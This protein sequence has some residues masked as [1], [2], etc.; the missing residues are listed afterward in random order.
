MQSNGKQFLIL[1]DFQTINIL[2]KLA[3]LKSP[4]KDTAM[5][6]EKPEPKKVLCFV[7]GRQ[8]DPDDIIVMSFSEEDMVCVCKS[9]IKFD[10]MQKT[11]ECAVSAVEGSA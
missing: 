5:K 11:V 3:G 6:E 4:G 2:K 7:C 8:V 10:Y 9:H 1:P